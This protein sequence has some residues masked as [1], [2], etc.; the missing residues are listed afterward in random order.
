MTRRRA[1]QTR[2]PETPVELGLFYSVPPPFVTP[3]WSTTS[4]SPQCLTEIV[5]I[6][7]GLSAVGVD[8]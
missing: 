8:G 1:E 5:E 7:A 2:V 3:V 6:L 4:I